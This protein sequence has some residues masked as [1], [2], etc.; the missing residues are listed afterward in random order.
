MKLMFIVM[1]AVIATTAPAFAEE[2]AYVNYKIK[3]ERDENFEEQLKK[4]E[5]FFQQLKGKNLFSNWTKNGQ[6]I[7][8]NAG[9]MYK[10]PALTNDVVEGN[11]ET[12]Y[13]KCEKGIVTK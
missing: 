6:D 7:P 3:I 2:P 1:A 9:E 13:I 10:K 5:E 12:D 4:N 8:K 11:Q